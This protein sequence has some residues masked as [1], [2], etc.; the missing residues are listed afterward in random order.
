MEG[1]QLCVHASRDENSANKSIKIFPQIRL[2][3]RMHAHSDVSS[4]VCFDFH[5]DK[6]EDSAES[7]KGLSPVHASCFVF[8][9][10]FPLF[11]PMPRA[12][13]WPQ[14]A[15][16][17]RRNDVAEGNGADTRVCFHEVLPCIVHGLLEV[18]QPCHAPDLLMAARPPIRT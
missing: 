11:N 8:A 10:H 17:A 15:K 5:A 9:L 6:K 13:T 14:T 1:N 12:T 7:R 18:M 16:N 4:S 2:C 3:I